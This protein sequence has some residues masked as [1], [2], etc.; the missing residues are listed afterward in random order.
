MIRQN[1]IGS[2]SGTRVKI[3]KVFY[4]SLAVNSS[5][6]DPRGSAL[7]WLSRIQ[8]LIG[9]ADPDPGAGKL[10]KINEITWF[11]SFQKCFCFCTLVGMFM[12]YCLHKVRYQVP[13]IFHIEV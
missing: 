4:Q 5:V 1:R 12:T 13:Y 8:I 6:P 9:N 7:I 3:K 10:T 2:E 11:P